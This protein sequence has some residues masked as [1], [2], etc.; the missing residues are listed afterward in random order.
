MHVKIKANYLSP[1]FFQVKSQAVN[2]S[3]GKIFTPQK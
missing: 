3:S 1:N 2:M